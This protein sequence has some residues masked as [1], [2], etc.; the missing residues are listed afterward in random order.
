MAKSP[1]MVTLAVTR[2]ASA[3]ACSTAALKGKRLRRQHQHVRLQ[4]LD[5]R[6]RNALLTADGLG[7]SYAG[8]GTPTSALGGTGYG[9]SAF[10][11]SSYGPGSITLGGLSDFT[12]DGV[13]GDG[14]TGGA[15]YG[16]DAEIYGYGGTISLGST[17]FVVADGIGGS[18]TAGFGGNGGLGRGGFV[19]LGAYQDV[20]NGT[21]VTIT[22]GDVILS[23]VGEGGTGGT[24]DGSEI[25]PGTGG[26]GDGGYRSSELQAQYVG[27][28]GASI[29][30][31]GPA[32][33][34][35]GDL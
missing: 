12:A 17:T 16:G 27:S 18:A 14:Q 30:V 20:E 8:E 3:A 28:G 2:A 24:G 10:Y 15:G 1:S 11:L 19:R 35:L 21:A 34:S 26:E 4:W 33:W 9:G 23:S 6:Y 32:T 29:E 31:E 5:Q 25:A 22:G 13:G 7:G